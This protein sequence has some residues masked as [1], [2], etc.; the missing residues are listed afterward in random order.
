MPAE[1]VFSQVKSLVKQNHELFQV[2]ADPR[3]LSIWK[4]YPEDCH[5]H[6]TNC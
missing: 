5:C 6:L 1:G 2:C 3:D 4:G